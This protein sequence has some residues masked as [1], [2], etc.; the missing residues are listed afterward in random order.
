MTRPTTIMVNLSPNAGPSHPPALI[1]RTMSFG[2]QVQAQPPTAPHPWP[3]QQLTSIHD[4]DAEEDLEMDAQLENVS[5]KRGSNSLQL[6]YNHN[7]KHAAQAY[8]PSLHTPLQTHHKRYNTATQEWKTHWRAK[9]PN[10]E[11]PKITPLHQHPS[12]QHQYLQEGEG[13]GWPL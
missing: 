2:K 10:G 4:I 13:N 5:P 3:P 8:S 11:R 7:T 6:S 12:N 1:T 9:P